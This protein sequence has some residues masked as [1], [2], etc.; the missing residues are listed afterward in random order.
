MHLVQHEKIRIDCVLTSLKDRGCKSKKAQRKEDYCWVAAPAQKGRGAWTYRAPQG[1]RLTSIYGADS[2]LRTTR[3]VPPGRA[4]LGKL[5]AQQRDSD[6]VGNRRAEKPWV[7]QNSGQRC[8][9]L[10]GSGV[11]CICKD[12]TNRLAG[13]VPIPLLT[14][15][16][17]GRVMKSH[18]CSVELGENLIFN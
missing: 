1:G 17:R 13:L 14:M 11:I 6:K 4:D 5:Q 9:V 15:D 7:F 18:C 3:Q 16:S 10:S 2:I 8:T 12:F